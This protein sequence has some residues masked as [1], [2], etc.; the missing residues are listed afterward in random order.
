VLVA[1]GLDPHEAADRLAHAGGNLSD[2][3]A[4]LGQSEGE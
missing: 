4:T 1:R 2:A 3:L